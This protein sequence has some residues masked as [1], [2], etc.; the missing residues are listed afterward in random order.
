MNFSP[1]EAYIRKAKPF[2]Q[3]ILNH[4]RNLIQQAVPEITETIKWGFPNFDYKGPFCYFASFKTH[5]AFGLQKYSLLNELQVTIQNNTVQGGEGMGNFGRIATLKDLPDDKTMIPL[6]K[7][8]RELNEKG[9]KIRPN[10]KAS[11]V[12][13]FKT[14]PG[15][16]PLLNGTRI[17]PGIGMQ[18]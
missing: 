7:Q 10:R 14:C 2:A 13:P 11:P 5:I 17:K 8:A 18:Q 4:P 3:P 15:Y 12:I 1:V 16:D 6:L 9:I